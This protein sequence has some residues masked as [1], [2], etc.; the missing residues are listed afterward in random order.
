M[1][2]V[3]W[4]DFGNHPFSNLEKGFTAMQVTEEIT[5][6]YGRRSSQAMTVHACS[7]HKMKVISAEPG[8]SALESVKQDTPPPTRP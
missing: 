4:C 2:Q 3:L 7:V 8:A 5:D 6:D 1:S